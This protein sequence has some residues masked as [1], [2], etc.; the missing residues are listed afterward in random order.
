MNGA[1]TVISPFTV[2]TSTGWSGGFIFTR[3]WTPSWRSNVA[4]G[5]ARYSQPTVAAANGTAVGNVTNWDV[6]G[7]LIWSPVERFDI[8]VELAYAQNKISIQNPSAAYVAA[9]MPGLSNNNWSGKLR[10]ERTF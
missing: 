7:N 10:V 6:K 3:Y 1:G 9:G 5:Y 8:G 2:G 4:F